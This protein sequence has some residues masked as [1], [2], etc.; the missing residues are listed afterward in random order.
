MKKRE[1]ICNDMFRSNSLSF[2]FVVFLA[3]YFQAY[4][5]AIGLTMQHQEFMLLFY[6]FRI[7]DMEVNGIIPVIRI[8]SLFMA[9][10]NTHT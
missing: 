4:A 5:F 10:E 7:L 1:A 6:G 8:Q 9:T 3:A 2:R